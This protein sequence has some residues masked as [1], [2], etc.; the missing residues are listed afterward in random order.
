MGLEPLEGT[1]GVGVAEIEEPRLAQANQ[2]CQ[3]VKQLF[4][5]H[6]CLQISNE[7][8]QCNVAHLS[9]STRKPLYLNDSEET[10]SINNNKNNKTKNPTNINK[11]CL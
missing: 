6:A 8:I 10:D 5:R 3:L 7:T 4:A 9:S 11:L 1:L 2:A